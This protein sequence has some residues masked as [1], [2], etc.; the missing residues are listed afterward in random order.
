MSTTTSE[1]QTFRLHAHSNVSFSVG[2][3]GLNFLMPAG[4][5]QGGVPTVAMPYFLV[6]SPLIA[7][8]MPTSSAEG[9]AS[10]GLSFSM[11]TMLSPA[12]F[13]MAGGAFNV[14]ETLSSPEHHGHRIP[15]ATFSPQGPRVQESPQPAQTQVSVLHTVCSDA[16][17][18]NIRFQPKQF[19]K[20]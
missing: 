2:L 10:S 9:A 15:V 5:T 1:Y 19:C 16:P 4:H 18:I 14:A 6:P 13:V 20:A 11:P 8:T 7:G 12:S 17:K 3:N